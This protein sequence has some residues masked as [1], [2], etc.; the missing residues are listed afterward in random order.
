MS[1]T[2]PPPPAATPAPLAVAADDEALASRL[3]ASRA[4]VDAPEA[5]IRRAIELFQARQPAAQAATTGL[6]LGQQLRRLVATLVFDSDTRT[7]LALG[8]RSAEP[9]E[10]R[11]IL[12]SADGRDVDLRLVQVD[13]EGGAWRVSGQILGPDSRGEAEI[14][15]PSGQRTA[16]P[17]NELS[18]FSFNPVA[19][20]ACTLTLRSPEWEIELPEISLQ[21]RAV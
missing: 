16:V 18:E 21:R 11:Q 6:G 7:P 17:W 2:D 19:A 13:A 9:G 5:V 8:L 20:S 4:M 14:R 15:L 1:R 12:Y 10:V 3:A